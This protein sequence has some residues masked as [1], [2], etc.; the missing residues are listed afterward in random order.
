MEAQGALDR[1]PA[2]QYLSVHCNISQLILSSGSKEV[3]KV[4]VRG[5]LQ[6][7]TTSWIPGIPCGN[8]GF[9]TSSGCVR[10]GGACAATRISKKPWS[11]YSLT[12]LM[13]ESVLYGLR[14]SSRAS[15]GGTMR[16]AARPGRLLRRQGPHGRDQAHPPLLD[17]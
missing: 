16:A 5:F 14:C 9:L 10:C 6:I 17:R 7:A 12:N 11:R 1:P 3:M 8:A 2:I 4:P 13:T 15:S